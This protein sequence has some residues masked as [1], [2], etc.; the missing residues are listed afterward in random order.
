MDDG[1]GR[2]ETRLLHLAD[3]AARSDDEG[4]DSALKAQERQKEAMMSVHFVVNR[5]VDHQREGCEK[6]RGV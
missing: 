4:T 6:K 1:R 5:G 3:R 2:R